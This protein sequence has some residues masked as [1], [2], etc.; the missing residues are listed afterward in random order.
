M[1]LAKAALSKISGE[2]EKV[3]KRVKYAGK[4]HDY[5][6]GTNKRER[7]RQEKEVRG[8]LKGGLSAV[9]DILAKIDESRQTS[10]STMAKSK[11]DWQE[12]AGKG[13]LGE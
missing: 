1:A 3:V 11:L 9:D 4:S 12:F 7:Q 13:K 2:S 5:E 8:R 6:V 10:S